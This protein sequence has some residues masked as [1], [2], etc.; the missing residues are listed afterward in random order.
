MTFGGKMRTFRVF[1]ICFLGLVGFSSYALS[2]WA[3]GY[4]NQTN[5]FLQFSIVVSFL[6][7]VRWGRVGLISYLISTLPAI[8]L[9][10]GSNINFIFFDIFTMVMLIIPAIQIEKASNKKIL[11]N[12]LYAIVL[13]ISLF[14]FESIGASLYYWIFEGQKLAQIF[15][16]SFSTYLFQIIMNI[17]VYFVIRNVPSLFFDLKSELERKDQEWETI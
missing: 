6:A 1:D 12:K 2:I 5:Y 11:E 9:F 4:L 17:V 13:I 14:V 7:I 3:F 10:N 8:T 15:I 16:I